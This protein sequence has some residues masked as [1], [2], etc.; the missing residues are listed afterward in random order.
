MVTIKKIADACGVSMSTVSKAL[1]NSQDLRPST[2][3][4]VR[5]IAAEMGYMPN[6]AARALKT[7]RSYCFGIVY[8][9]AMKHGL[10]H[11]YFSRILNSFTNSAESAGYDVF[12][13]GDQLAGRTLSYAEHALYRNCDGVLVISGM[14]TVKRVANELQSLNRPV[15][16]VD[17]QFESFG[18]VI[19]DNERGM[20][21]LVTYIHSMGHNQIAFI[22]GSDTR[23]TRL[24]VDSFL[25]TCRSLGLRVPR[26]YVIPARFHEPEL[27]AEATRRLLALPN[28]PTCILYPDDYSYIGGMNELARQGLSAPR[29]I[30]VAGYDGTELGQVFSPRLTTLRQDADS[31]GASAAK[32]LVNAVESEPPFELGSVL[33]PGALIHGETVG[34]PVA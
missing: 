21:D 16:C 28:P 17:Y 3:A 20:R 32:L 14:D 9:E 19:S 23:V 29:D 33:I 11:E 18:S 2:A 5:R 15:V 27:A 8:D 12:L 10:T 31:M 24:R 34:R 26:E 25:Q 22:H 7:S 6:A 4:R 1:N 13:L 30:S